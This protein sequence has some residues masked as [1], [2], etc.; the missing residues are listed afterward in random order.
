MPE[1]HQ[2]D[3]NRVRAGAHAE[4]VLRP[5]ELRQRALE[6]VDFRPEDKVTRAQHAQEGLVQFRL[7]RAVLRLE[8]EQIHVHRAIMRE[9]RVM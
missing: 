9:D 3:E 4:G 5:G 1:R 7:Q 8:I 2:R 6:P